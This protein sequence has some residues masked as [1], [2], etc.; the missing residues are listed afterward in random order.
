[1]VNIYVVTWGEYSDYNIEGIFSTKE[2]AK[3]YI[4]RMV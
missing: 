4:G 2:L 1:M 3:E